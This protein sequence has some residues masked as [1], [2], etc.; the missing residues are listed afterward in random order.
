MSKNRHRDESPTFIVKDGDTESRGSFRREPPVVPGRV[1][2]LKANYKQAWLYFLLGLC[3]LIAWGIP[4]RYALLRTFSF[5]PADVGERNAT[6]FIAISY[7]G[8]SDIPSE[9]SP[10]TFKSQMQL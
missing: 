9:V 1:A 7:E 3:L 4:I 5:R 8:I 2:V 10:A 6:E